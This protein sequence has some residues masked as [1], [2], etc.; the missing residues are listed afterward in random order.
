VTHFVGRRIGKVLHVTVRTARG[1]YPLPPALHIRRHSP[2]G[3]ECGYQGSG[4]AQLALAILHHVYPF[5]RIPTRLYQAYK[6]DVIGRL[7]K[8]G[9]T[10]TRDSVV[11]WVELRLGNPD[12]PDVQPDGQVPSAN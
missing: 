4:C 3:L 2:T 9:W 12:K 10:L 7:A 6:R 8:S 5:S 1:E 11:A